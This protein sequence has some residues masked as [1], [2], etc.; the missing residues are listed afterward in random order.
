MPAFYAHK[1]FGDMVKKAVG[2]EISELLQKND[3]AFALGL[4]GP[5]FLFYYQ[6]WHR[7][8]VAAYGIR[9]HEEP[10]RPFFTRG[11]NV[12]GGLLQNG[13]GDYAA[14][15]DAQKGLDVCA[16]QEQRAEAN[17]LACLEEKNGLSPE[18]QQAV[19]YLLGALC[20][21]VLDSVCHP[22]VNVFMRESGV[23]HLEIE[24]EFEK[25]LLRRDRKPVLSFDASLHISCSAETVAAAARFYPEVT[26]KQVRDAIVAFRHY[27]RLLTAP[28]FWK[29]WLVNRILH[30]GGRYHEYKGL[31]LQRRD[32]PACKE[33]NAVLWRQM[34]EAVKV[35]RALLLAFAETLDENTP[36]P[37]RFDLNFEGFCLPN[38]VSAR[39]QK[40][41]LQ[42]LD[43]TATKNA[44]SCPKIGKRNGKRRAK[45]TQKKEAVRV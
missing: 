15:D 2:G 44:Q 9:L 11:K 4:Q 31:M 40:P 24:E 34:Q 29:Q 43:K 6:P 22:Y 26:Q 35:A 37:A 41:S 17:V 25:Y 21:F 42:K 3:E 45:K 20:H 28:S 8:A 32:N 14:G 23:G 1:R 39:S 5:D 10:A 16:P 30:I 12:L 19:A 36:L 27:K 18:A 33:S 7:N 13:T 38:A